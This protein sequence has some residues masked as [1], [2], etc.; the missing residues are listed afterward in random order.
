MS[1]IKTLL[2]ITFGLFQTVGLA[3]TEQ[4]EISGNWRLFNP[5]T[6]N[7]MPAK[8]PGVVHLDL[9]KNGKIANPYSGNQ[10]E[11]LAWIEKQ[12]WEYHLNFNVDDKLLKNQHIEM[13]F[14][15]LDTYAKV[16][17]NDE[18]ILQ[19]DNMFREWVIDVKPHLVAGSNA[20]KIVFTPPLLYHKKTLEEAPY[21]LPAGNEQVLQKVSPYTRKA[22]YQF[23][24]DFGPRFVSC[25]IWRP[26]YLQTWNTVRI[27]EI[28]WDIQSLSATNATVD[29]E[30]TIESD[31][32]KSLRSVIWD[33]NKL[34]D[35]KVGRN[36][37]KHT[38][39]VKDPKLWQPYQFGES[40]I[41]PMYYG[42]YDNTIP[43][44]SRD[45]KMAF[46]EI[47]LIQEPD[48][49][50]TPFYFEVNGQPLFVKGANYIPQDL[51]LP[52]VDSAHYERLIEQVKAANINML[53]VWGG[54]IYENNYFYDLCDQNG[55]L[56]WQDFMFAN[57][58][59][60]NDEA[61]LENVRA[62]VS[63]NVKRLRDHPSIALWCGNNEIE[64]AWKN[65]GWQKQY[66]YSTDQEVEIWK[67]YETIFQD[68]IP[69]TLKKLSPDANYVHTTPLSNWGKVE[70]F[71]HSTMHYWGV[72][73]G[74]DQI[75]DYSKKIGRFMA[76]YGFQSYP[77]AEMLKKYIDLD[78]F[79]LESKEMKNRQKSYVGNELILKAVKAYFGDEATPENIGL[80]AWI[81]ASQHVQA[82]AYHT[83]ISA[84][85]MDAPRCM[86]TMFWQLNDCW[87][88]ASWS[89]IDYEGQPKK[90]YELVKQAYAPVFVH[91]GKD[92]GQHFIYAIQD[93]ANKRELELVFTANPEETNKTVIWREKI[94]LKP[95]EV[96]KKN[97]DAKWL[98]N[99]NLR[100][101]V[102]ENDTVSQ[103][104]DF[105][106]KHESTVKFEL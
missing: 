94:K 31:I 49:L 34:V 100:V 23:G 38:I 32:E 101:D 58:M 62:E 28:S 74:D 52:R 63:D 92:S 4:H 91:F 30:I 85:R 9:L 20:L 26:V 59:Y 18:E 39:E 68:I 84:H 6:S 70:N 1:T 98:S 64:V 3:R 35:I 2:L 105:Y 50:G 80:T 54:G 76:E 25:G 104:F 22:G 60:P 61:F 86:G 42:I 8:V 93:G 41:Q 106:P 51:F 65:W 45:F 90:A 44:D 56:V 102:F 87:P 16:Y 14:E 67:N 82:H 43:F 27:Q 19:A 10:E 57:A 11:K 24:W 71:N 12:A 81:E 77:S 13:V 103:S 53:R 21:D 66:G 17:L 33:Q 89:I 36:T 40:F 29:F 37:I 15:G 46:R 79:F 5:K 47:A 72:W 83:A 97:Y 99:E 78:A 48:S 75:A 55:I 7:Y 96:W 95:L 73:H 88:G 69:K